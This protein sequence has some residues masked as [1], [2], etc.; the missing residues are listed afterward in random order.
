MPNW[1]AQIQRFKQKNQHLRTNLGVLHGKLEF[2]N[3]SDKKKSQ[4]LSDLKEQI[5][6]LKK[7]IE[8]LRK[9]QQKE[10]M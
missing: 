10:K 9:Q 2:M 8:N 4:E 5:R 1:K 3:S 7:E 6:T